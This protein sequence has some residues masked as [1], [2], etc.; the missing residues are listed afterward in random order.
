MALES[1][2]TSTCV[3]CTGSAWTGGRSRSGRTMTATP[4]S[5]RS[6]RVNCSASHDDR[7]QVDQFAIGLAAA[8]EF[9]D[10]AEHFG[11]AHRFGG[12]LPQ[13]LFE[14]ADRQL[15]LLQPP[16]AAVGI[17]GDDA[18][19]LM[20]LVG[21]VGQQL[22]HHAQPRGVFELQLHFADLFL[23]YRQLRQ[24]EDEEDV[25]AIGGPRAPRR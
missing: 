1:R 5:R 19:R 18:Q 11:H 4:W 8:D 21:H 13:P 17:I 10:A 2:L 9:A 6:S 14:R 25:S 7:V 24:I 16:Q 15:P 22:A 12:D 23:G 3:I 20:D